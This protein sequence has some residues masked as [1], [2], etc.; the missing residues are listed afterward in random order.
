MK[1]HNHSFPCYHKAVENTPVFV[2]GF[3]IWQDSIDQMLVD[4]VLENITI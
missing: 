2:D 1:N 4:F 3:A